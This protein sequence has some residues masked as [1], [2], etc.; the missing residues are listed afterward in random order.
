LAQE[1]IAGCES[2]PPELLDD[3]AREEAL[4]HTAGMNEPEYK[5]PPRSFSSLPSR[6]RRVIRSVFIDDRRI[7][8]FRV[9]RH[10]RREHNYCLEAL[11]MFRKCL[12]FSLA[13]AA[14][15]TAPAAAQQP[16]DAIVV[17][18]GKANIQIGD[19]VVDTA[20]RGAILIVRRV[21]E[22]W[23][24]VS[25]GTPGWINKEDVMALG[26]A[27]EYFTDVLSK[28]PKDAAAYFVRANIRNAQGE[29]A[30][31]IAD[32]TEAIKLEPR[33]GPAHNG[34]GFA[35]HRLGE[36]D[37]AV[38]D[39]NE[40]LQ[41]NNK[42]TAAYNNRGIVWFEKGEYDKA[43]ADYDQALRLDPKHTWSYHNRGNALAAKGE[44][45]KAIDDYNEAIRLDPRDYEGYVNRGL[46]RQALGEFT[47]ALADFDQ[48]VSFGPDRPAA[49]GDRALLLA[50]CPD[51]KVRDG[52]KAVAD[53]R[54]ACE[55][56]AWKSPAM[57]SALA[58][59]SAEAGDFDAAI[60]WQARAIEL[61]PKNAR[62][63]Y[64]DRLELYRSGKTYRLRAK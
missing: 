33:D 63:D 42:D 60:R 9:D 20:Y 13:L 23:F 25:Q 28:N 22:D 30:K 55:L 53:A 38:A 50:A 8:P 31:A 27:V 19:K 57:L 24:S 29:F 54:R 14:L 11:N 51:A 47:S 37:K 62:A 46:A 39:F 12:A 35:H 36:L 4:N 7:A 44:L 40:A 16:G 64:P 41:I 26:P 34:R 45:S 61:T 10:E 48:A 58:A 15:A 1:A 17:I 56:T 6:L 52:A 43:I 59:A 5:S 18:P 2:N 32:Y 49:H 21:Q 3:Y